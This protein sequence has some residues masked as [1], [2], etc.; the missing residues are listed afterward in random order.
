MTIQTH[1]DQARTRVRTERE[2]VT[3]K[4]DAFESFADR[5]ADLPT[6]PRPSSPSGV[7]AT[8]GPL[9]RGGSATDDRCRAVRTAF[10]ETIRPHSVADVDDPE[11]L[12]ATIKSEFSDSIAVALAPTT[13]PSFTAGLKQ[14]VLSDVGTRRTEMAVLRLAL[15]HEAEHLDAAAAVVDEIVGWIADTDETPLADLGFDALRRRH[16]RLAEH[17]ERCT[18]LVRERQAFLRRSTN[19]DGSGISHR[20]LVPYLYEDFPVDHPL[21]ATAARLDAICADCQRAVRG[22][23][24]RSV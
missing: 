16:E 20:T 4:L 6:E 19:R 11:S 24:V 1:V 5:V 7:T 10:A 21:L 23:L 17:R 18:D 13:E 15:D 3:A 22:H 14:A 12:L 2:A 8:A 9:S